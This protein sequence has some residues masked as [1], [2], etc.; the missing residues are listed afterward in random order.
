[1]T[2]WDYR[3]DE[4]NL[5]HEQMI[6]LKK[7]GSL[8]L[9]PV[10]TLQ[11][12]IISL[13]KKEFKNKY[14]S[15]HFTAQLIFAFIL[16][17]VTYYYS[18]S[19]KSGL[20]FLIGIIASVVIVI[21]SVVGVLKKEKKNIKNIIDLAVK[22]A[23]F[24]EKVKE[25]EGWIFQIEENKEKRYLINSEYIIK[26]DSKTSILEEWVNDVIFDFKEFIENHPQ[27][28]NIIDISGLPRPKL[29]IFNAFFTSVVLTTNEKSIQ[30]LKSDAVFLANFQENVGPNGPDGMSRL[31]ASE[32]REIYTYHLNL[33]MKQN[34]QELTSD[35]RKLLEIFGEKNEY[36]L[37][38]LTKFI[39][40]RD[41][42]KSLILK[43]LDKAETLRKK[44]NKLKLKAL[45]ELEYV[46]VTFLDN[47][48]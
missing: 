21:Y 30:K 11:K 37:E 36:T 27:K 5:T 13:A 33:M 29:E 20:W 48:E 15:G 40:L 38:R 1:M 31:T 4:V 23:N 17:F 45:Q 3:C 14:P 10:V 41:K 42:S 9:I 46:P 47:K 43:R 32:K 26:I 25:M 35:E 19:K 7:D 2:K 22:D 44:S 6:K 24:F 12:Q 39:G 34:E 16:P 18:I 8:N 28:N